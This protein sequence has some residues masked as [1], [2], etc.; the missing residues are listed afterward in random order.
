MTTGPNSSDTI[1]AL[2]PAVGTGR[3]LNVVFVS[4]RI[5]NEQSDTVSPACVVSGMVSEQP[6]QG[7]GTVARNISS[8]SG[9]LSNIST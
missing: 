1:L 9:V 8:M 5:V 4:V 6:G 7:I 3:T 2:W